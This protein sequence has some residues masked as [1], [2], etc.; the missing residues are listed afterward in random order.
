M[1][2]GGKL[3]RKER[4]YAI[5]RG[6]TNQMKWH[7]SWL[8]M[9]NEL[10]VDYVYMC[11]SDNVIEAPGGDIASLFFKNYYSKI[12]KTTFALWISLFIISFHFISGP[13]F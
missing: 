1:C 5:G 2:K 8:G 3:R 6:L 4:N 10:K 9:S 7:F 11:V 13:L 12:N